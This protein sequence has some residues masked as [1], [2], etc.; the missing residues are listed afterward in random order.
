MI[1]DKYIIVE[2]LKLELR[3]SNDSIINRGELDGYS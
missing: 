2:P 1:I 3:R